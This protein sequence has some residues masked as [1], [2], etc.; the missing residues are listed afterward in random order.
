MREKEAGRRY[1]IELFSGLGIYMLLLF[2]A[3]R[4][5][6]GM[7]GSA[8]TALMI[9]PM[10]GFCLALWAVVRQF[11]RIDEYQH[12]R[13]LQSIA[14]AAAVT[15]GWTFTYGFLENAGFPR[16]SMFVIWPVMGAVW[17][18]VLGGRRLLNL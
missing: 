14:I 12:L 7:G 5:A 6:P 4:Y 2:V 3:I 9:S 1:M 16:L 17:A 10:I 13:Q 15:A 11:M 8:G 18:G